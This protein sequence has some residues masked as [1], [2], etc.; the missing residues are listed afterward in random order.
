MA[1]VK[2]IKK[3]QQGTDTTGRASRAQF[4]KDIKAKMES[5]PSDYI[6]SINEQASKPIDTTARKKAIKSG[7]YREDP[8]TGDLFPVKKKAKSGAKMVKK[9]AV[10][11]VAK[12]VKK[13]VKK[14]AKKK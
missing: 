13:A 3:A 2:K 14:S 9:A 12:A 8:K 11:K 1:K 5:A 7:E 4:I 10:K 6:R